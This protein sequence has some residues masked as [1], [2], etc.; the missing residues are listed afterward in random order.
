MRIVVL[1]VL[2][3]LFPPASPSN[4]LEVSGAYWFPDQPFAEYMNLWQEG[5]SLKDAAG[6]KLIYARRDMPLGGYA[7]IYYTNPGKLPVRITDLAIEG[8]PLSRALGRNE[9]PKNAEDKFYSSLLL[10]KLPTAQVEALKNAGWPVWWR[11]E[12]DTIEPGGWGKITL[13]LRRKPKLASLSAAVLYDGGELPVRIKRNPQPRFATIAFSPDLATV[14]LYAQHP[15]AGAKPTKVFIDGRDVSSRAAIVCDKSL[16]LSPIVIRL[17]TPLEWM[18][19]HH[20]RAAYP[21]GSSAQAGIRAWGREMVYGM[22]SSPSGGGDPETATKLFV[23]DYLKHNI[24]CVMPYVVGDCA[25]FFNSEAGWDYCESV[26]M[27]R[28]THWPGKRHQP[29]FL[30]AMDE[31]DANDAACTELDGSLRLGSLGQFLVHWTRILR[32]SAPRSAILL[33]IDNTYK[34]ENWYMYHQ[35]ADIPCIDPYYTEQQDFAAH[36]DPYYFGF[37]TRPTYV[38]AVC[39]I[40]QSSGQPNPLHAILCSTRYGNDSGYLGRFPT[41]E[42]KRMEVYYAVG[43]GAKGISYWWFAYDKYCRGLSEGTPEAKALW[44]EIGLLGA[45]VRTAGPLI[46]TS[47]P[48]RLKTKASRFLWVRSLLCGP[49]TVAVV[50]VNDNAA[51]DRLGTIVKPIQKASVSIDVPSWLKPASVFE[52]TQDG[53]RDVQSQS[54]DGALTLDLGTV[55]VSRFVLVT[56]DVAL[57]LRLQKRYED[58]FAA[59]VAEL[60]GQ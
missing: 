35:L 32:E 30:F 12:P 27:D 50:V 49:G 20:F 6:D 1:S 13:R 43:S 38:Q 23:A 45:E 25:D 53:I 5:W 2:A 8:I 28:M 51:S 59:N 57:R 44:K 54:R 3:L 18:S 19:Y 26:G 15:K 40:S 33:N 46:T 4:A 14:Y 22:W 60:K 11:A 21:D 48:V 34:P 9:E 58:M 17:T 10:S 47:C 37:H 31:P 36:G 39:T 7:F 24:N 42:E 56:S 52:V 55:N 16:D 29:M 41:P